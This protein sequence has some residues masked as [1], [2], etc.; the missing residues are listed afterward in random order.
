MEHRKH[1]DEDVQ[2]VDTVR[3]DE[4]H[5][6]LHAETKSLFISYVPVQ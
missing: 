3:G 4:G 5:L 1:K 6:A 2:L